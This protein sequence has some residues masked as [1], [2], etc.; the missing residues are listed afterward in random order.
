MKPVHGSISAA[1]LCLTS[2]ALAPQAFSTELT[3]PRDGWTSWQV[4]A[5]DAAPD[6]CCW[7][8]SRNFRDASRAACRLDSDQGG[9]GSRDHA[10]TDLAR[11]YARTAGGRIDRFRVL[12]A[13]CPVETDTPIHD[14]GSVA[15]DD[16][17][18]WLTQLAR[19]RESSTA[20]RRHSGDDVLA[21][22][23]INR[24]DL[25]RDALAGIA[26]NDARDEARKQAVFWLALVRGNEGADITSSVMF[27]DKDAEVREH[28]AFALGQSK[29]PRA[30]ADLVRLGN[31]DR[32]AE[33]RGQAWFWLAHR[34]APEAEQAIFAALRKEQDDDVL[35]R[36]IVALSRLPDARAT[37]ALIAAAED[38]SL[39]R[40]LR[41]RAVFW[42]SHSE[43]D[44]A[45]AYLEQILTAN[46]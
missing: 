42:L 33:V 13:S 24:G 35:D 32:D 6:W 2:L 25:A 5:V 21:A 37:R 41:K 18:R 45:Q 26:R 1:A 10:K 46:Y 15:Q 43:S 22:L 23:A 17:A 44:A 14:L 3:L 40:E 9:Y 34:A 7:S 36:A 27:N 20:T 11:I 12:S 16:S 30:G 38:R 8:D 4:A 39:S 29:S 31:T 19:Q 28:A